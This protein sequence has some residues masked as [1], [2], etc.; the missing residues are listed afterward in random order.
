MFNFKL[1][2]TDGLARAGRINTDHGEIRTPVFMPVA[3]QGSV[4]ALD[5]VDLQ[6][7]GTQIV[8]GNA[9][10]LYLRPGSQKIKEFGGL[11]SFMGWP[12]SI[13][14]DSGGFQGFS[15]QHLRKINP[16]GI[17][18]KSHID[19]S[20]HDLTPESVIQIQNEI[21]SDIMMPLDVCLSPESSKTELIE[22]MDLTSNW[23]RRSINHHNDSSTQALFGIV[24]GGLYSD[25]RK[26]SADELSDYELPGYSIGGLSVGETKEE[27]YPIVEITSK[28]L[29]LSKPRYLMGVGSPEDLVECVVRGIDMF[30]CV[31]PTRVA[32]KGA[33]Y[34][35]YGR[36][37]VT[38]AE[39]KDQN[40]SFDP[41]C[42]CYSC[43]N[44]TAGYI[45]HLFK[46]KEYLA[47]RLASIHNL[48]F[49]MSIMM[50]LRQAIQKGSIQKYRESFWENYQVSDQAARINQKSQ[51]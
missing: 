15:L 23:L 40:S 51:H 9:Y 29:P 25:L 7:L 41:D 18:F 32:R 30:D 28:L 2:H 13:L 16:D 4:K 39:Y 46:A 35:K 48:R 20:S 12:N 19:G 37:N 6:T 42:D 24:Q 27:M 22:A 11:H 10:H 14:T 45:H 3:T 8:L 36:R 50:D 38:R 1:E 47:Y 5:P 31:L 33:M 26:Q 49:L 34:T 43:T 17:T 44:F 21:G